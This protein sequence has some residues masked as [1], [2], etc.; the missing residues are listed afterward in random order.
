MTE[1]DAHLLRLAA[2]NAECAARG[3][4]WMVP[5]G[6]EILEVDH[7]WREAWPDGCEIRAHVMLIHGG[8]IHCAVERGYRRRGIAES[9]LLRGF[10]AARALGYSAVH[11]HCIASN[12]DALRLDLKVGLRLA[13]FRPDA[14]EIAGRLYDVVDLYLG[15]ATRVAG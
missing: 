5:T 2:D 9:L 13:G 11:G 10:D 8:E 6:P 3:E 7:E 15:L 14:V 1:W 4:A 12:V